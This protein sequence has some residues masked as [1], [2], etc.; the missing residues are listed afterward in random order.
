MS[1]LTASYAEFTTNTPIARSEK[2]NAIAVGTQ[3]RRTTTRPMRSTLRA[4]ARGPLAPGCDLYQSH[5]GWLRLVEPE[6]CLLSQRS[7]NEIRDIAH[8][9]WSSLAGWLLDRA[10]DRQPQRRDG[11]DLVHIVHLLRCSGQRCS[12]LCLQRNLLARNGGPTSIRWHRAG[13]LC[14]VGLLRSHGQREPGRIG[15][16]HVYI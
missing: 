4:D 14:V 3:P 11:V 2:A 1:V 9:G 10:H 16:G 8:C 7:S 12:C 13:F 6:G 15:R 5:V